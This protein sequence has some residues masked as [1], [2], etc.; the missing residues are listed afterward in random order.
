MMMIFLSFGVICFFARIKHVHSPYINLIFLNINFRFFLYG[1]FCCACIML[2]WVAHLVGV[3]MSNKMY[4]IRIF[5][6]L[7]SIWIWKLP[8]CLYNL[9]IP[10]I[11]KCGS[12]VP[13]SSDSE[14]HIFSTDS[15]FHISSHGPGS[16]L[17]SESNFTNTIARVLRHLVFVDPPKIRL[18]Q[19]SIHSFYIVHC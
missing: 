19:N 13:T 5:D 17:L 9:R 10:H 4:I 1:F 3:T 15:E 12:Q 8:V 2:K 7:R 14:S 16:G 11:R 18:S 6:H